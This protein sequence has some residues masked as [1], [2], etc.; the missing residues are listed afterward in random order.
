MRK[1]RAIFF[2]LDG[3]LAPLD[4]EKFVHLYMTSLSKKAAAYGF[5]GNEFIRYLGKGCLAMFNND[6][7]ITNEQLF[8]KVIN[9]KFPT[10]NDDMF[11]D[12]YKNE[13]KDIL[14]TV[15][16]NKYAKEIVDYCKDNFEYVVL[17]TN[18][19]FPLT[20]TRQR[21]EKVGLK[22]ED[23]SFITSYENSSFCKPNPNYFLALLKK[24]NL[25]S[26]EVI[27]IGN[28]DYED[29]ECA[30]KAGIECVL[31]GNN[32]IHDKRCT[33][34]FKHLQMEDVIPFLKSLNNI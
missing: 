6:G 8:W 10:L 20:A 23:F 7:Q 31:A 25:S 17:S 30:L 24:F 34:T 12:Y 15:G 11:K 33:C 4:E 14:V 19:L 21:L 22:E 18:P 13:Y 32:L 16:E 28:N 3:T 27:V 29:G 9:D 5:D 26:D 1:I 2:D